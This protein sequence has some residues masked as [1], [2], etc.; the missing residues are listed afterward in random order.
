MQG[1]ADGYFVLPYTI[2]NYLADQAL[3]PK[4]STWIYRI[5]YNEATSALRK[6]DKELLSFDYRMWNSLSDTE[7]DEELDTE[8]EVQI[9]KLQ[10]AKDQAGNGTQDAI[11]LY[12][13][14]KPPRTQPG[15]RREQREDEKEQIADGDAVLYKVHYSVKGHTNTSYITL[16]H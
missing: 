4:L 15:F 11:V 12:M 3:W 6:K 14:I 10:Q 1:L 8:N 5:A 16:L 9:Q 13:V 2:Q 7:I